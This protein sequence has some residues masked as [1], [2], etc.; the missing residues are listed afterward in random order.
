MPVRSLNS[1]VLNWPD[2]H[3]VIDEFKKWAEKYKQV[4]NI[5]KIGYF[6]SYATSSYGVGSDLDVII[7]LNESDIPFNRRSTRFDL[8]SISVPADLVIYTEKEWNMMKN[9]KFH[10]YIENNAKWIK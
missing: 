5:I 10:Q 8:T 6:G 3:Q 9:S 1:S 2:H 7:I 4:S